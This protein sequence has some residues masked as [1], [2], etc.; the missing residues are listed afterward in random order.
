[1]FVCPG[2]RFHAVVTTIAAPPEEGWR[3]YNGR[4]DIEN[5][6]KELKHAFG[7]DGLCSQRSGA[8][9]AAIRA[10]CV[11]YNL[12]EEFHGALAAAVRR[13]L[14]TSRSTVFACGAI[15]GR[16]R[17]DGSSSASPGRPF[18][19]NGSSISS[20]GSSLGHP[21][22]TQLPRTRLTRDSNCNVWVQRKFRI[23]TDLSDVTGPKS[24]TFSKS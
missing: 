8:T 24:C 7:A 5:R 10:I 2:Y 11:L 15:L 14:A 12:I 16:P 22:T 21:S 9:E 3:T 19:S 4:A 23:K 6:L 17:G 1:M 13:A 20:A 18:V